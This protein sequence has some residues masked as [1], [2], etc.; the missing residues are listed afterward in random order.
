[1][2]AISIIIPVF[3]KEAYLAETITS[4]LKQTYTHFE[5]LL[6]NDGSTDDSLKVMQRFKD[7]RIR[8]ID[9]ENHG[10]SKT[11]NRGVAA[12]K[13][14]L[15]ALLDADDLWL[16]DHLKHLVKLSEKF[17]ETQLFATGYYELF[18]S[19]KTVKPKINTTQQQPCQIT[20]FFTESLYQPLVIPSTLAFT[21]SSFNLLGGFNEAT[22]YSEDVD[23]LIRANLQFK[24][25]YDP[26]IT[27]H[28]R[29]GVAGQISS[30]NKSDLQ[31]PKFGQLLRAHPDHQSLHVYIHTKRYF[32]CIF[33]K[34]EGRLDLFKKLKA[35]LDTSVLNNK[36]RFLLNAPRFVLISIRTIKLFLLRRG[37][38]ITTF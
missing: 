7:A 15:I 20:D 13:N 28:Y 12:A 35:K 8:I 29:T 19:G 2:T 34:T 32:L 33:Y 9:Q 21:K 3:N 26:K 4:V 14:E 23:F 6:I 37:F 24:M 22:T 30:L 11:R 10:L 1:M 17:P 5:L 36:Q 18:N 25:A 38:R 16:P 27:C 31:V